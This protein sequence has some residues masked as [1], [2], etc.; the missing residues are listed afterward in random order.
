MAL[1]QQSLRQSYNKK[2]KVKKRKRY[3]GKMVKSE[4]QIAKSLRTLPNTCA[5][6]FGREPSYLLRP[7]IANVHRAMT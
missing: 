5:T 2:K 1:G 3:S 6:F 4:L 7:R